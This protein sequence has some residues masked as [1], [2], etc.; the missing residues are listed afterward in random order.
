MTHS[1][2]SATTGGPRRVLR[3][4]ALVTIALCGAKAMRGQSA[5]GDGTARAASGFDLQ[6][7]DRVLLYVEGERALT[8]TFTVQA[9]PV[10]V[11]PVI[12]TVPVGGVRRDQV[13]PHLTKAIGR[14]VKS[15][16]VHARALVRVGVLG[17]VGKPGF[18]ALPYDAT[19]SDALTVAGGLTQ[20]ARVPKIRLER[21]GKAVGDER[22]VQLALKNGSTL[23]QFGVAAGDQFIVPRNGDAERFWRI[24]GIIVTIPVAIIAISHAR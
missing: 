10:L 24:A 6:P 1:R 5:T 13:E 18:Y 21:A 17:E 15:P 2:R 7:G 14:Y 3:W 16:V 8:D 23:D 4:L 9:G 11:L 19:V 20:N 12:G 22:G